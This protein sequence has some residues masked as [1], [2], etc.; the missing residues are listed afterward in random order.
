MLRLKLEFP[1]GVAYRQEI[2]RRRRRPLS[3]LFRGVGADD[4]A[5]P[6]FT[7]QPA[8]GASEKVVGETG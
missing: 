5:S 2:R 4:S 1:L 6:N 8:V 7:G 3:V